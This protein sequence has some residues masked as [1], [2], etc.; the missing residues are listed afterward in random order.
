MSFKGFNRDSQEVRIAV[1]VRTSWENRDK[2]ETECKFEKP[3]IRQAP[4]DP[5]KPITYGVGSDGRYRSILGKTYPTPDH[6]QWHN[7]PLATQTKI[8]AKLG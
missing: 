2:I 5:P 7:L 1:D 6:P 4:K 8:L 3:A